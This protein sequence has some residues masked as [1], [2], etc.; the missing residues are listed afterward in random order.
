MVQTKY[1]PVV[2]VDEHDREI[3]S[4]MLAEVWRKGLYHRIVVIFILDN[5]GRM[6]LQLRSPQVGVYPNCWDQA[7]GGHVDEGYTYER[8]AT[9]EVAEELGLQH[10]ALKALGTSRINTT[11]DDGRILNRF[12][13]AYVAHIPHETLLKPE[14][15]EVSEL[16]WF[17]PAEL[18]ALIAQEPE[19]FAPGLIRD[20]GQHFPEFYQIGN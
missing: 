14:P 3:G 12:E 5:Q 16:R 17:T 9:V 2:V 13:R 1:P 20:L 8:A 11:L 4:A 19:K 10:V 15:E 7:A 18:K 6:L